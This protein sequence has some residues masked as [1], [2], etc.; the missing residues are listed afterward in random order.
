[1]KTAILILTYNRLD[2]LKN[3]IDSFYEDFKNEKFDLYIWDN[4]SDEETIKYIL[5]KFKDTKANLIFSNENFGLTAS[6]NW[7]MKLA[8]DK[9]D[10]M[11]HLASD[12]ILPKEDWLSVIY[13]ALNFDN[14]LG[15]IGLNLEVPIPLYEHEVKFLTFQPNKDEKFFVETIPKDGCIGGMHFCISKKMFDE[16]GYFN[17]EFFYGYQDFLYTWRCRK[18]GYIP[19]YLPYYDMYDLQGYRGKHQGVMSI[20][21]LNE[22]NSDGAG[23]KEKYKEYHDNMRVA[24]KSIGKVGKAVKFNYER[25]IDKYNK[26]QVTDEFVRN[27]L[28]VKEHEIKQ[29]PYNIIKSEIS[30]IKW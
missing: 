26:S 5:E 14:K 15:P 6:M 13:K 10:L 22:N 29:I 3:C 12:I 7:F 18:F 20:H 2:Y 17:P 24:I 27:F 4:N 28:K 11:I 21:T 16:V 8:H 1:M 25:V 23:N 19:C 30:N 9:Y